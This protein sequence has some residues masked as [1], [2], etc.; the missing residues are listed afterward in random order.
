MVKIRGRSPARVQLM[1]CVVLLC[2][3]SGN[4]YCEAIIAV[5]L[6]ITD[7]AWIDKKSSDLG[8]EKKTG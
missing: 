3:M 2:R 1:V 4:V 6:K 5:K 8:E 7:A